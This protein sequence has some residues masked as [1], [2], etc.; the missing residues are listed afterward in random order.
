MPKEA[1]NDERLS[2]R[3]AP[4]QQER[5]MVMQ[6][7][8][9]PMKI[10]IFIDNTKRVTLKM[11]LIPAGS[12][13]MGS[14][15]DEID[16][17]TDEGPQ[18]QV[19]ITQPFYMGIY[20]VTQAQ[21]EV[22]MGT[23]PSRGSYSAGKPVTDVS[24]EDCLRFIRKLNTLGEGTYRLPTEAEWEYACR[25]GSTTRFPWGDDPGY[26]HLGGYGWYNSNSGLSTNV[27]GQKSAN[28]WG[29]YDM[30]GNVWEW[31]SDR[32]DKYSADLKVDPDGATIGSIR[33]LRGGS[34]EDYEMSLRSAS[35]DFKSPTDSS[36][37][38][39]FRLVRTL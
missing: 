19:T 7:Q 37:T 29:L 14:P 30:H 23:Q 34:W 24:Y 36:Y 17:S 9:L 33:T 2:I 10:E 22:V 27:V 5:G 25:A 38:V 39:G 20:P 32:Y 12:L 31:C 3:N 18:H 6:I 35:R 26:K 16:R 13:I 21:W 28:S 11:V 8:T 1:P 15:Y 4:Q